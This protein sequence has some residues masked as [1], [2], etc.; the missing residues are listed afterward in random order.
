MP[1][2]E[3]ELQTS[4]EDTAGC[5]DLDAFS[6]GD[7]RHS[8]E[9]TVE[10]IVAYHHARAQH[11]SVTL[12][13]TWELPARTLVGLCVI[14]WKYGPKMEHPLLDG[15]EY[16]DAAYIDVITLSDRYRGG[17]TCPDGT[18]VSDFVLIE[19]L[20][21]IEDHEGAMPIVQAVIE[22][23]NTPS[24]ELF[25]RYGFRQP[26]VTEPDLLYVRRANPELDGVPP[27]SWAP[28]C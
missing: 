6:C 3:G 17:F 1:I 18:P 27:L 26:I 14:L 21:H 22:R 11:P 19:A 20:R 2:I 12:R 15:P 25:A 7:K 8:Y 4:S 24:Q 5:A 13:V 28:A 10:R 16:Q 23:A 9:E